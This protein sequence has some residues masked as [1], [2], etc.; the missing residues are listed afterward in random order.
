[1]LRNS[2]NLTRIAVLLAFGSSAA[3]VAQGTQTASVTLDA[4]DS[5]GAAMA[6]VT[7]RLTSAKL[8]GVRTGMT[9]KDGRFI[10]R[11][12]PP[13]PYVIELV[14]EGF[15]TARV[16]QT[17]G[18]DQNFQP[19]V[20]MQKTAQTTVVVTA[21][22]S[23][24]IDKTDVKSATNYRMDTVDRL[25][26]GRTME[27]VALLTPGVTV[28]VGGRVQIRGA[29]TS[30]NLYLVDGQNVADNAYNNRGVLLID[31]AVE[32]TQIIT[33]ALSAEYGNVEGGVLNAITKSGSNTFSGLLRFD[34]TNPAWN[35]LQPYQN[36]T[37]LANKQG[38][39]RT[40]TLGGFIIPDRLW[41]YAAYYNT[42]S[43]GFGTI[44]SNSF[45]S[46]I[47]PA[48]NV[49]AGANYITSVKEIRRSFKLTGA[50]NQDHTIVA[51]FGNSQN[52]QGNR[53]Y[54]A[55]E[56]AALDNQK[57]TSQYWNLALR[58]IWSPSFTTDVRYGEKKQLLS[59]GPLTN[60]LSPIYSYARGL[61]YQNGIFNAKDG[62][63]NRNNKT[64]DAKASLFFDASGQHQLDFGIGYLK[65]TSKARNEQTPTGYIFGVFT[66]TLPAHTARGRDVWT[67]E[68][69]L[70]EATN[71]TIG[72]YANDKWQLN[73]NLALQLGIRFDK[74][75]A[76]KEDGST[77][78]SANGISPRLGI[79]YDLLGDSKWIFK[80]S[81]ARY[82]GKVLDGITNAVTN[83]GNPSETDYKY[84]GPLGQQPWTTLTNLANYDMTPG[85][86]TYFNDPKVNVKLNSGMKA[87]HVDE[88]QV[89]AAYSFNTEAADGFVSVTGITKKWGN[90]LDYRSGNDGTVLDQYGNSYYLKVWDNSPLAE[91]KYK[92]LELQA[93]AG[94]G[95]WMI[96]GNIT[97]STL[98]GNYEGE[99]GNTPGRG[100]GLANFTSLNGVPL[101][102]RNVTAPYGFL[103]GHVPIRMRWQGSYVSN[104]SWGKTSWGL[105]YR[106]DSGS[107]YSDTR[108]LDV[109]QLNPGIPGDYGSTATQYRDNKRGAYVLP[110]ASYLDL[111]VTHDFPLF[112]VRETQVNAFFKLVI[113]NFLNHQQKIG[114][115]TASD[116]VL[117]TAVYPDAVS[118]P[119]VR[120][121]PDP[122]NGIVG[123][124]NSTSASNYGTARTFTLSAGVRF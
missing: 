120:T 94:K 95:A 27:A 123:Y 55:G 19:R 97:W 29:M 61:F 14:K 111:A 80:A 83:Q 56:L 23:P 113:G 121:A 106:F 8:Q 68:S 98:E 84:I 103:A 34:V 44:S 66:M 16:N 75:T 6:G 124:G 117:A 88:Y 17:I 60:D 70:G 57:N 1:M 108:V 85:G 13:G 73:S 79:T 3:L 33:G 9:D 100:E 32:E 25:P 91:R 99:G 54:S 92:G 74:Y 21:S 62:G 41:F 4:A 10:A 53:N 67:F 112:K 45:I 90:L 30:A 87:P 48:L 58:S 76:K 101:Y 110:A 47:D 26:S 51:A 63:D 78:A 38:E 65:G 64:F 24:A 7:V 52:E 93:Q 39:V 109:A 22:A 119:W 77:S 81:A 71:E 2:F 11:L 37:S 69:S 42:D 35:S 40:F 50:I 89:S 43:T 31:D 96:A 107:H 18:I 36:K 20:T 104:N 28:G 102:D 86:V 116:A 105:I 12:L 15:Q 46:N 59:A 82:N 115:N 49:G 118:S 114:W 72:L 122:A 5:S